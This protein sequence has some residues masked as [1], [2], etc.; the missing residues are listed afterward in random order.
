MLFCEFE[1]TYIGLEIGI[2]TPLFK[3]FSMFLKVFFSI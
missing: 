1:T 3:L 2:T